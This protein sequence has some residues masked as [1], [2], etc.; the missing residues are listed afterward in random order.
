MAIRSNTILF[1]F[2]PATPRI[3]A[4]DIHEW[5]H[6]EIHI[7]EQKV[8]MIQIDGI[9]RQVYVKLTDKDYM[10][11]IIN[12]TGGHGEYKHHTWEISHVDIA[13]AGMGYKKIRV[14]NLPPELIDNTLRA[15]L[16]P[17]GQVLNIQN[18]MWARTYR[19]TVTNGV[20]Q[21]N[22]MLTKLTHSIS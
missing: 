3:T 21:V 6:A 2:D 19:Y 17:L 10:L 11:S 20:R 7:Q 18:E 9:K 1:T 13:V 22:M 15:T 5:L 4:H 12:G 8:Q 14:P 16:A